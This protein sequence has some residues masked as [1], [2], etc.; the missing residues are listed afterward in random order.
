MYKILVAAM[1][2]SL[3]FSSTAQACIWPFVN[4]KHHVWVQTPPVPVVK[5]PPVWHH[6]P[7]PTP[8]WVAKTG[9]AENQKVNGVCVTGHF[10]SKKKFIFIP[11]TPVEIAVAAAGGFI[12]G[13]AAVASE[14]FVTWWWPPVTV[15][16]PLPVVIVTLKPFT[17][18]W[19]DF[20]AA[21]FKSFDAKTGYYRG[22]DHK[23]HFCR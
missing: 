1:A 10:L 2:M 8:L 7:V 6:K 11:L 14:R 21:K 19:Y 17:P 23:H 18:Q 15:N 3:V 9:C 4:H 20:C 22:Y 12:Q 5:K 13:A 16:H